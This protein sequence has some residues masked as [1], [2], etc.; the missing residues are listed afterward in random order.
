MIARA[1]EIVH[2]EAGEPRFKLTQDVTFADRMV[3]T[4][5]FVDLS[6]GEHPASGTKCPRFVLAWFHNKAA[7]ARLSIAQVDTDTLH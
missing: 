4:E 5:W 1:G 7:V 6:T 2:D 3:R